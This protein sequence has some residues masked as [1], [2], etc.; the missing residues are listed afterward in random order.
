LYAI[1][2]VNGDRSASIA[3]TALV[4][5]YDVDKL[6][7]QAIAS[8]EVTHSHI[9]G[10]VGA[11]AIALASAWAWNNRTN[12]QPNSQEMF[13]FILDRLPA[14]DTKSGIEKARELPLDYSVASAVS[15]LGN[16]TMISAQDTVPLTR[17]R[18][19]G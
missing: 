16:G 15:V 11:L 19:E 7:L 5:D 14:S 4:F 8:A 10:R 3:K 18:I 1:D 17:K 2:R 13:A 12:T 6:Q 9:E